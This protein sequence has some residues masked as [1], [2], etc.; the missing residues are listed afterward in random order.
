MKGTRQAYLQEGPGCSPAAPLFPMVKSQLWTG[1]A[2]EWSGSDDSCI[3]QFLSLKCGPQGSPW[4]NRA[5]VEGGCRGGR[6][7][8]P[9]PT[10]AATGLKTNHLLFGLCFLICKVRS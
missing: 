10:L 1:Y 7:T 4:V 3:V 9:V 6:E 5:V 8:G 2:S